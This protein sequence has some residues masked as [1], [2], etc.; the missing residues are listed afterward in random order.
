MQSK[1]ELLPIESEAMLSIIHSIISVSIKNVSYENQLFCA[2]FGNS[3]QNLWMGIRWI[4]V[5]V[6]Q[7]CK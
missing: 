2:N 5:E 4:G 7:F 6:G 1:I 3:N